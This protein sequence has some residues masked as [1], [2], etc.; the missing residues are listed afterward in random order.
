[1]AAQIKEL[2]DLVRQLVE[3]QK[4]S[5]TKLLG[6][7]RR[8]SQSKTKGRLGQSAKSYAAP[9]RLRKPPRPRYSRQHRND[10]PIEQPSS[11]QPIPAVHAPIATKKNLGNIGS[12]A[13][14][15]FRAVENAFNAGGNLIPALGQIGQLMGALRQFGAAISNIKTAFGS[16]PDPSKIDTSKFS[17]KPVAKPTVAPAPP[18]KARP[19]NS[20]APLP[21]P[22]NVPKFSTKS[23]RPAVPSA[24][25]SSGRTP[26]PVA[27]PVTQSPPTSPP[28]IP[29]SDFEIP[30]PKADWDELRANNPHVDISPYRSVNAPL[31]G[32]NDNEGIAAIVK[33]T[34]ELTNLFN[35]TAGEG[36]RRDTGQLPPGQESQYSEQRQ[37][38]TSGGFG[39]GGQMHDPAG[40]IAAGLVKAAGSAGL[41]RAAT[42]AV[43]TITG[44]LFAP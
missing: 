22:A 41:N 24:N 23:Y 6:T 26:L 11:A 30:F 32:N 8:V 34:R 9:S 3:E 37:A 29:E 18:S 43:D 1:M 7:V 27:P 12:S 25:K 36:M 10:K 31:A 20:P 15:K 35:K 4:R 16:K 44:L 38:M 39:S 14:R 19:D 42:W 33:N 13:S 40:A 2:L 5:T 17:P 21:V 28:K